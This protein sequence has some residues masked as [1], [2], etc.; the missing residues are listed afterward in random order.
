LLGQ[1]QKQ[2]DYLYWEF[3]ET[4]TKQAVRMGDWKAI[5]I[6][7][8]TGPIQLYN[9]NADPGELH[10]VAADH[11]DLVVKAAADMKEAHVP[12]LNF[13]APGEH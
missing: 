12:S 7:M 10:D 8:I 1:P 5:R 11:P 2:H 9:L 13:V 4:G 3:Y 6:P